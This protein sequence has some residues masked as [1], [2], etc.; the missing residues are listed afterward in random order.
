[1]IQAQ[2][3]FSTLFSAFFQGIAMF[4][5]VIVGVVVFSIFFFFATQEIRKS[6]FETFKSKDEQ[7]LWSGRPEF[8][9]Y[10][11]AALPYLITGVL[12][13]FIIASGIREFP[14]GESKEIYY[15]FWTAASLPAFFFFYKFLRRGA[16][17]SRTH[18]AVTNRRI[19]VSGGWM[20]TTFKFI[21]L[22]NTEKIF[23]FTDPVSSVYQT[24]HI[25]F[26]SSATGKKRTYLALWGI[27]NF[28]QIFYLVR[29]LS[30]NLK[31][32]IKYLKSS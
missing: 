12:W 27:E 26:L 20:K 32:E 8:I 30:P 17:Y 13:V 14:P 3:T 10:M 22:S 7:I 24:A 19:L 29:A 15:A 9:P 16:F 25:A 4:P 21:E 5:I 6:D 31:A 18:Y 2:V 11:T 23:A 28:Q 1:L